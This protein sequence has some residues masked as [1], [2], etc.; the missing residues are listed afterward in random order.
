MNFDDLGVGEFVTRIQ[1]K[2]ENDLASNS[3]FVVAN[4]SLEHSFLIKVEGT[5]K[6]TFLSVVSLQGGME[7]KN[8]Q[9]IIFRFCLLGNDGECIEG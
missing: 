6:L 9:T 1:N 4:A 2:F 7:L 8:V 5:A 3:A